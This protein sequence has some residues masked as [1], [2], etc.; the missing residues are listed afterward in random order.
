MSAPY[1][2]PFNYQPETNI[3]QKTTSYTVPA[4]KYALVEAVHFDLTIDSVEVFPKETASLSG[5]TSGAQAINLAPSGP[6]SITGSFSRTSDGA[7]T[8][9]TGGVTAGQSGGTQISLASFSKTGSQSGTYAI[10]PVVTNQQSL[11]IN[12]GS[13]ATTSNGA[14]SLTVN[15][16]FGV[17]KTFFW[18]K[19][20]TELDGSKYNVTLYS[21]IV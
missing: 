10:T 1:V 7:G 3:A 17:G 15:V 14:N 21:A 19:P 12:L 4:N 16:W 20:G 6:C 9:L 5:L 13:A 8:A 11:T 2:V 18:V